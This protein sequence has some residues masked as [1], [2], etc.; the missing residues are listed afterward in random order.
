MDLKLPP[1]SRHLTLVGMMG[2][3]KSAVSQA[4][5]RLTNWKRYDADTEIESRAGMPITEIFKKEGEPGFRKQEE[6]VIRQLLRQPPGILSTGGGA[7]CQPAL[8]QLLLDQTDC[9][10]L[11]ASPKLLYERVKHQTHRPLLHQPDPLETLRELLALRESDYRNAP[12]I[13]STEN[14]NADAIAE[15]ILSKMIR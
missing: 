15:E 14:K 2:C 11:E 6:A 12:W 8:Q 4:L 7:F 1:L 13:V 3:G 10:Y 9:V 5:H